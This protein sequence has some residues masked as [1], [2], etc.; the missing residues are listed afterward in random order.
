MPNRNL[1]WSR[2]TADCEYHSSRPWAPR[3]DH[4]ARI[5]RRLLNSVQYSIVGKCRSIVS[6]LARRWSKRTDFVTSQALVFFDLLLTFE[7]ERVLVWRR[8]WTGTTLLLVTNRLLL[9]LNASLYLVQYNAVVRA[10]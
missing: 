3:T 2:S 1:R 7:D 10:T 5:V 4:K 8:K 6:C 9:I